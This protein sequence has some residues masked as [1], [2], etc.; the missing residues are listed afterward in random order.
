MIFTSE[1]ERECEREKQTGLRLLRCDLHGQRSDSRDA[2]D[3][4]GICSQKRDVGA[5]RQAVLLLQKDTK[6]R[7]AL[8]MFMSFCVRA[9]CYLCS[10]D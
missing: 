4:V 6:G 3:Q 1:R 10:S 8:A 7:C 2:R 9:R 5:F